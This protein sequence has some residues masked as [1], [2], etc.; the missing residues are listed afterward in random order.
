MPMASE[1]TR[2]IIAAMKFLMTALTKCLRCGSFFMG[3]SFSSSSMVVSVRF[4]RVLLFYSDETKVNTRSVVK[5]PEPKIKYVCPAR[6]SFR[7]SHPQVQRSFQPD[8]PGE[9]FQITRSCLSF[10]ALP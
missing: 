9:H 3:R 7:F 5:K 1:K 6:D 10:P 8:L 2:K 4:F